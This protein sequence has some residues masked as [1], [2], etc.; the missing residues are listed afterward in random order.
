MWVL[1]SHKLSPNTPCYADGPRLEI[2]PYKQ[3]SR[4]DSSNSFFL[5]LFNHLGTHVDAPYHFDPN[6]RKIASYTSQ[7]L[8]FT[9][10][11]ILD[12]EKKAGELI[13]V[14]DLKDYE[15]ILRESD[16]VLI[17]TGFQ[18]FRDTS[19]YDYMMNGPCLSPSAAEFLTSFKGLRA[20][21]VDII[22]ISSPLMRELGRES[23]RKLLVG[24]DFLIIEDMDLMGKPRN[25]RMVVVA[26]LFVEQVDSAP[27]TVLALV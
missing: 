26:P 12:V 15:K 8:V 5:K 21:G 9:K 11:S 13:E 17:R 4:G 18:R 16:L 22:S 20:L 19:P 2:T 1:L 3:I 7:E 10:P 23:H 14:E 25:L 24:R 27:C 6:G